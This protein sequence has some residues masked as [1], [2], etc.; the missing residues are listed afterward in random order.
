[1]VADIAIHQGHSDE[2]NV[3][4]HVMLTMRELQPEGFGR[5]VTEWNDYRNVRHWRREWARQ[6]NRAYREAGLKHTV[7]YRSYNERGIDQ[8]PQI[9]EGP[10]GRRMQERDYQP[11][12]KQVRR[13]SWSGK[14]RTLDYRKLDK[15]RT[16]HQRNQQI[17]WGNRL[18]SHPHLSKL[19]QTHIHRQHYENTWRLAREVGQN[20]RTARK[21]ARQAEWTRNQ[22]RDIFRLHQQ[23]MKDLIRLTIAHPQLRQDLSDYLLYRTAKL[24]Q[25]RKRLARRQRE[26]IHSQRQTRQHHNRY[27]GLK[28]RLGD[29]QRQRIRRRLEQD[30][31]AALRAVPDQDFRTAPLNQRQLQR[32]L[33][34]RERALELQ[35]DFG[36]E[37]ISDV[38]SD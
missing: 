23:R 20:L 27:Q 9:H 38:L 13:A 14:K 21:N 25:A 35:R 29:Q 33:R 34:D 31:I 30:H 19:V 26:L 12:S 16:R 15:G 10:K 3:H 6:Q 1:M 24:I 2:R 28:S 22:A 18:R 11:R 5:K 8:T 7:D 32:L 17:I 4:A 36:L 37:D